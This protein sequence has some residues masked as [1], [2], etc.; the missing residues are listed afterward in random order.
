MFFNDSV[1]PS[2]N[3]AFKKLYYNIIYKHP[4]INLEEHTFVDLKDYR[5]YIEKIDPKTS[6]LENVIIYKNND[7]TLITATRG[8]SKSHKGGISLELQEESFIR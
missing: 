7:D 1:V 5:L 8:K 4:V 2:S 6:I 3:Y